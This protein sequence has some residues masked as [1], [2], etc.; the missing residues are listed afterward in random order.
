MTVILV[1]DG[2]CSVAVVSVL[3]PFFIY[4]LFPDII[5]SRY[6]YSPTAAGIFC[7]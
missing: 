2:Q 4:D 7:K 5:L 6:R 3:A 1:S